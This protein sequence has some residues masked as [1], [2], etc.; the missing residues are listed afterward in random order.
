MESTQEILRHARGARRVLAVADSETKNQA[1][2]A[3]ADALLEQTQAILQANQQDLLAAQSSISPVMQDR[4]RLDRQRVEAMA[5]G[6]RDVAALPDPVGQLLD[7]QHRPNG[8]VLQKVTVPM[9]VIAIIYESRPNVTSDAAALA[10]K[11]GSA[12]VLRGG[13]EAFATNQAIVTALRQG[14]HQVGLPADLVSLIQDTS[15]ESATQLMQAVG[16][17]DLLIPRGGAGLIRACV[18]QAKVPCIQTGTGICHIY[19]DQWADQEMALNVLENAKPAVP[20][21]AMQQRSAWCM[22][23]LRPSFCPSFTSAWCSSGRNR[24]CSQWNCGWTT[25]PPGGLPEQRPS[26]MTLIRNFVTMCWQW[27]WCPAWRRPWSILMPTPPATAKP[28]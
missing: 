5:Q 18:E 11:S 24:A 20:R 14:L 21:C 19:V 25:R 28:F 7:T 10:L 13:K 3:M 1:L 12:C 22:R 15:R 17:V 27:V 6:I 23:P 8:L 2:C 9:G 4:L 26:P 16:L